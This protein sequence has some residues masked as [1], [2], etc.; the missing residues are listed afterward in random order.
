MP[1]DRR[2]AAVFGPTHH[3]CRVPMHITVTLVGAGKESW[4]SFGSA[5]PHQSRSILELFV[6]AAYLPFAQQGSSAGR[7]RSMALIFSSLQQVTWGRALRWH[8][9]GCGSG[10]SMAEIHSTLTRDTFHPWR[11]ARSA[12]PWNTIPL[13]LNTGRKD[14]AWTV[15]MFVQAYMCEPDRQMCQ[16]SLYDS[17]NCHCVLGSGI[18]SRA[19]G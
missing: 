17:T 16:H 5:A 15:C 4:F 9:T 19:L 12:L 8:Y 14:S 1:T 18:Y 6:S 3:L 7:D 2:R 13:E 11:V 10:S